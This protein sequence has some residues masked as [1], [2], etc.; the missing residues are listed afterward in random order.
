M[1]EVVGAVSVSLL[2]L[3]AV[4][5]PAVTKLLDPASGDLPAILPSNL[6]IAPNIVS[7]AATVPALELNP[8]INFPV[9]V[10][11]EIAVA[12]C[13]PV[14]SPL[15]EPVNDPAVVAV[16]ALPVH[17]AELPS[18]LVIPVNTNEPDALFNAI[19]VVP[20][21]KVADTDALPATLPSNLLIA[22]NN[23]SVAATVPAPET[24]PVINL[25][26][27]VEAEIAVAPCVPVT[28]PLKEPVKPAALPVHEPAVVA[29]AAI[30]H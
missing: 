18:I 20:I 3:V 7:V 19:E 27:T 4:N 29:V 5:A 15:K 10:E 17:E 2:T 25:P 16:A 24:N 26:V 1:A 28:S 6:L 23:E 9:T 12:L 14:T 11:A 22:D 21:Y 30:R 13:V 8:V